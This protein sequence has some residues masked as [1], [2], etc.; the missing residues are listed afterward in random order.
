MPKLHKNMF[1]WAVLILLHVGSGLHARR[2]K[3]AILIALKRR[4]WYMCYKQMNIWHIYWNVIWYVQFSAKVAN[5][6]RCFL[7]WKFLF[8]LIHGIK[9]LIHIHNIV[10]VTLSPIFM[11]KTRLTKIY[12]IMIIPIHFTFHIIFMYTYADKSHITPA[13]QSGHKSQI[14]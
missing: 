14:I 13:R 5:I 10:V 11:I 3:S 4:C 1:V 2:I 7:R 12:D 8:I 9:S 6:Y